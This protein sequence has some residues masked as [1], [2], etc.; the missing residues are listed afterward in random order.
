MET[1]FARKLYSL[2][3]IY[4]ITY[5]GLFS[6]SRYR[7]VKSKNIL[8][9]QFIERIMLAVTEVNKCEACSYAHT[10]MAL[11]A[12][13]TKQEIDNIL[14]GIMDDVPEEEMS[15]IMFA[16][17]YA[18]TRG[19]PTR[20]SLKAMVDT[21]GLPKVEGIVSVIRLIMMGNAYGIPLGSFKNR[22]K[23][24]PDQR[25]ILLY[26]LS[27][28]VSSIIFFPVGLIHASFANMTKTRFI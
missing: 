10:K 22:F 2:K 3:E 17:H 23:G 13:M 7:M 14:S 21:Y 26:E 25:S 18:E 27:V 12:G 15:T 24:N 19:K 9:D 4:M 8:S 16:K 20:E 11:E 1:T 5:Y 6:I 28:I